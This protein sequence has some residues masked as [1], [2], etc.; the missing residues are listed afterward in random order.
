MDKDYC[1]NCCEIIEQEEIT[2]G[3]FGCG[4]CQRTDCIEIREGF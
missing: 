3:E 1:T 2:L 4:E